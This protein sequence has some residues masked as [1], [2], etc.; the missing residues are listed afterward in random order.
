MKKLL[1]LLLMIPTISFAVDRPHKQIKE[2]VMD[3][4]NV[5]AKENL[6]AFSMDLAHTGVGTH[7]KGT[8]YIVDI[9]IKNKGYKIAVDIWDG[10]DLVWHTKGNA[11]DPF[12]LKNPNDELEKDTSIFDWKN[13]FK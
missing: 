11:I 1:L 9:D 8:L 10:E 7:L 6:R 2:M 13:Y 3:V 4:F 12:F 5:Y